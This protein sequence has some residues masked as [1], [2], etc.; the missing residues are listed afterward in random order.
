MPLDI[1]RIGKYTILCNAHR[2]E[3]PYLEFA[4]SGRMSVTNSRQGP[5]FYDM[6][7]MV[8]K[9]DYMS[10]VE[11]I[12]QVLMKHELTIHGADFVF[13]EVKKYIDCSPINPSQNVM[14]GSA[15]FSRIPGSNSKAPG[16]EH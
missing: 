1:S 3:E 12:T 13:D 9:F 8:R 16:S 15:F 11:E 14:T 6:R 5:V 10:I 2:S 7:E 4:G